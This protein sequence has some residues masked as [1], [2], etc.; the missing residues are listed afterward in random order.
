[1]Q[2]VGTAFACA[3]LYKHF[4]CKIKKNKKEKWTA[5]H[6]SGTDRQITFHSVLDFCTKTTL[7]VD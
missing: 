6:S 7:K 3:P 2:D 1:M 5:R 4:Q